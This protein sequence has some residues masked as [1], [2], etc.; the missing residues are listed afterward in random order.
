MA[1]ST[2]TNGIMA[3][4]LPSASSSSTSAS[5]LESLPALQPVSSVSPIVIP[6]NGS[7]PV[8][9]FKSPPSSSFLCCVCHQVP[10]I[11]YELPCCGDVGCS[12]C[13][14][15]TLSSNSTNNINVN[16]N[17]NTGSSRTTCPKC[18]APFN[19][20]EM[21]PSAFVA[22][23]L[24]ALIVNCS[25]HNVGC[26]ASFALGRDG[27]AF[28][29]HMSLCEWSLISCTNVACHQRLLRRQL[30]NHLLNECGER[31][32]SCIYC[33]SV[34][35]AAELNGHINLNTSM[36]ISP[37]K[38]LGPC[39]NGCVTNTDSSSNNGDSK[40]SL[41]ASGPS[42]SSEGTNNDTLTTTSTSTTKPLLLRISELV[43]HVE[44][45]PL[46]PIPCDICGEKLPR[47]ALEKHTYD[48]QATHQRIIWQVICILICHIIEISMLNAA[49]E[50]NFVANSSA[51]WLR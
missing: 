15:S 50:L 48:A 38:G 11:P 44:R 21:R 26:D 32:V 8:A 42:S 5:S 2:P 3:S 25:N 23:Q 16:N 7:F 9:L 24:A 35:R 45:C 27:R 18:H 31:T 1:T 17:N 36:N 34:L 33:N 40:S 22:R 19:P 14:R 13:L 46:A 29:E 47:S 49:V 51:L 43:G 41:S 4:T 28:D 39:P 30:T 12:D 37:C 10:R 20:A 6:P